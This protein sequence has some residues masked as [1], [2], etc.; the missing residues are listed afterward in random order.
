MYLETYLRLWNHIHEQNHD[1][2]L[3]NIILESHAVHL[4]NLIEF[5]NRENN[6]I[7]T[8]TIFTGNLDMSYDD[9]RYK[10]KQVINKTIDHLTKERYTWN[11]TEKDLTIQFGYLIHIMYQTIMASRIIKCVDMLLQEAHV[12]PELI[13]DL[14][15]EKIQKQLKELAN[16]CDELREVK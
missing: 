14:H 13:E 6:C 7:T 8:D 10:A 2:I 3:K 1:D 12:K 11:Q 9:S 5:F 4:R 15:N 16:L